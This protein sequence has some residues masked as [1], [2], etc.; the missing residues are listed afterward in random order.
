MKTKKLL[1]ILGILII[2]IIIAIITI[3]LIKNYQRNNQKDEFDISDKVYNR[4]DFFDDNIDYV[5]E[6]VIIPDNSYLFFGE[7]INGRV[8]PKEIYETI[9]KFTKKIIPKLYD[10]L[11]EA[12]DADISNYYDKNEKSIKKYL[13]I[14]DAEDFIVFIKEIKKLK[15]DEINVTGIEFVKDT[16]KFM[17]EYTVSK[18]KVTYND[19]EVIE[20]GVKVFRRLQE[21]NRNVVFY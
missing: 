19:D 18:L 17:D 12:S 11:K 20:I 10:D 14:Y 4:A 5:A 2:I 3:I 21:A 1:R 9:D 16:I 8:E 13:E 7:Y 6:D 15:S